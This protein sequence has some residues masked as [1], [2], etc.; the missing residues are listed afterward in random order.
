MTCYILKKI[1]EEFF[2]KI[3]MNYIYYIHICIC[4]VVS[5][6]VDKYPYSLSF[7]LMHSEIAG[8]RNTLKETVASV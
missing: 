5:I 1:I 8:C 6:N 3:A 4:I 7:I 2:E